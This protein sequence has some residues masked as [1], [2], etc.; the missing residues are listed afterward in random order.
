MAMNI[1]PEEMDRYRRAARRHW[2]TEQHERV[3][4]RERGWQLAYQAAQLLRA[5]YGVERVVVFG[6]L[7][8]A[9]RFTR[10]SDV[11]IAAWGL[12]AQNWLKAMGAV[13][14]IAR[15][16]EVHLVDVACCSLDLL[17]AIERDGVD[18]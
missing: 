8:H 14:D 1:A 7:T 13:Y 6:S 3:T 10:W 11:D 5:E 9:D 12:T 15:D 2:Q 4:R 16:I 17:A 18:V